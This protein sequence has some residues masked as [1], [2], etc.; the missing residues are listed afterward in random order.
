MIEIIKKK[1]DGLELSKDEINYV[2]S[3]LISKEIP[4]YQVAAFLMAI[5]FK[6]LSEEETLHLTN[7]FVQS[8][9]KIDLSSIPGIKVDKHS[10]GGVGD[11]TTIILAPLI[12]AA[13]VPIAKISGRGLGHT[14]GTIDKL[15]S[16][17]GF[18]VNLDIKEFID[19]VKKH[20]IALCGQSDQLVPADKQLYALRDV[21]ATVDNVGLMTSSI[22]SK[23]IASGADAIIID[24]K[25]GSGAY[26]KS[27]S[28][29]QILGQ[30]MIRIA[31]RMGK[32]ATVVITNMD[33]P[34][35]NTIG[36]AL[37]IKEAIQTLKGYG[38]KDLEELCLCLGS[39]LLL[40]SEAY[41]DKTQARSILRALL[42]NGEAFSKFEE[43]IQS[44]SGDIA[45][46][47]NVEL[48]PKSRY[49]KNY[50]S[51]STGYINELKALEIGQGSV[52]L[53]AGRETKSS[54][55]DYGAGIVLNKKIG[56]WVTE[57]EI[58]ATLHSNKK[59]NFE[60]AIL[61]MDQA[62]LISEK[63]PICP[64]LIYQIIK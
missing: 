37:E 5:Y 3:G 39:E 23:K 27:L 64:D 18:H 17:A 46:I 22:M 32:K 60:Q 11:K 29:A 28:E 53:G 30:S 24:M 21:T 36:N 35:G 15:E 25:L 43:F 1:R 57:G 48:L 2:I 7:S 12:A 59:G 54:Q 10:T 45:Q 20:N 4:E 42:H 61:H 26:I 33:Q 14:G 31:N 62:Y 40:L 19:K 49:T 63:K 56:D 8:G 50:I 55:L 52:L 58:L 16:I 34:L 51:G 41:G 44:Q 9:K 13:G 6:Q 38:P 47:K